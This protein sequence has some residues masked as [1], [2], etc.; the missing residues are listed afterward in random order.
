ML[1]VYINRIYP[2]SNNHGEVIYRVEGT[3]EVKCILTDIS[4]LKCG[5]YVFDKC[6]S[7]FFEAQ[8]K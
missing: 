2:S 4:A 5:R 7:S 1:Y 3:G 6:S 8:E